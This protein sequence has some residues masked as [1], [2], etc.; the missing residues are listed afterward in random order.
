MDDNLVYVKFKRKLFK[1]D[2]EKQLST[3]IEDKIKAL[4]NY[5]ELK[6]HPELILLCCQLVE[7][8]IEDNKKL[9]I[10]KKDLVIA[11]MN[12][13]FTYN[14]TDKRTVEETIEFLWQTGK[15][16]RVKFITKAGRLVW[17][18]IKRKFL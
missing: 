8:S 14:P 1:A 17:S 6:V 15:I 11:V 3:V 10:D 12:K 13:L 9:K 7:N 5:T 16:H 4:P 18:W 2:L